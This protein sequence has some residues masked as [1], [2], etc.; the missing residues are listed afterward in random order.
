MKLNTNKLILSALFTALTAAGAKINFILP[1]MPVTLQP[2][3]VILAGC[4]IGGNAAFLS[5][6]TYIILGLIG[7]PVF[8]MPLAGPAYLSQPTFGYLL[9]FAAAAFVIGTVIEKSGRKSIFVFMAASIIGLLL[10]YI[11]GISYFYGLMNLYLGKS[12]LISDA[13]VMILPFFLKDFIIGI[14]V[15]ILSYNIYHKVER[16]IV[17]R[18]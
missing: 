17:K 16:I 15:S 5:Q 2:I 4:L 3:I 10:I 9:G 6:I 13:I 1:G 18:N 7:I 14:G 12:V 11:F 8:A